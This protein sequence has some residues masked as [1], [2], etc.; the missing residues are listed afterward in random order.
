MDLKEKVLNVLYD[1]I[2]PE[3]NMNVVDLGLVYELKVDEENNV[4]VK[5]TLTTPGCPLHDSIIGGAEKAIR[6]VEGVNHVQVDL[7]WMP[8][9]SPDK[10]SDKAK[11]MLM[12]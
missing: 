3:L 6:T 1:V 11:E 8:P 7:T 5:M 4:Y 2:D 12:L 10:M 9:W